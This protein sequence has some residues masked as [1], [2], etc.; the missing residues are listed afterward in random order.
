M[1][2]LHEERSRKRRG[3]NNRHKAKRRLSKCYRRIADQRRDWHFKL[4]RKLLAKYDMVAI[5]DLNL[6]GMKR[7]WGRKVSDLGYHSFIQ[8]LRHL[9]RKETKEV[10]Q[11][12][13]YFASSQTCSGCGSKNRKLSL[14]E[15]EWVCTECG[16][17]H[18]RD[19]NAAVNVLERAF[20]SGKVG[21]RPPGAATCDT[22]SDTTSMV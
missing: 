15:R 7:L 5:E 19:E 13:R 17:V 22:T 21:V 14:E 1:Q 12:D 4:A 10:C 9:A 8:I 20:S 6:D 3:S 11:V 16:C 2:Q 18:D